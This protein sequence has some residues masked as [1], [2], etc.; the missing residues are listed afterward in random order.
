MQPKR[1]AMHMEELPHHYSV[2]RLM[3][4][5]MRSLANAALPITDLAASHPHVDAAA[6]ELAE[7][8]QSPVAPLHNSAPQSA[9]CD[10]PIPTHSQA[11]DATTLVP[12]GVE[13]SDSAPAELAAS[14]VG[15]GDPR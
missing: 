10:R 6:L 4:Q 12:G 1:A 13:S 8:L 9:T 14:G 2:L 3:C 15:G 11:S 5:L 7:P